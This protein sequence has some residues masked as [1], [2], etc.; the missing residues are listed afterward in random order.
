VL[1]SL[2]TEAAKGKKKVWSA[3]GHLGLH[4]TASQAIYD[5]SM[6]ALAALTV[7]SLKNGGFVE[8]DATM[9]GLAVAICPILV[10]ALVNKVISKDKMSQL[11]P[12]QKEKTGL[13]YTAASAG[14]FCVLPIFHFVKWTA[15]I[16]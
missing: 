6:L 15:M 1:A 2:N 10:G 13:L 12:F 16:E 5:F 4:A 8:K 7:Y 9:L 3:H 11:W 14:A